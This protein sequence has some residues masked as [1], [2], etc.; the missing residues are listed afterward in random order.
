MKVHL[1]G[2]ILVSGK[3]LSKNSATANVCVA[4]NAAELAREFKDGDIVVTSFVN[5]DMVPV[6]RKAS[7]IISEEKGDASNAQVLAAALDI[8]VIVNAP[9]ATKILTTGTT[10]TMDAKRGLVYSGTEPVED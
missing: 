10:V 4:A 8:P 5:T 7:G 3:G 6:L 2:H 9:G 1:V